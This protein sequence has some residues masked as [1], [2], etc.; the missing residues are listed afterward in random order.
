[1]VQL[2]IIN[3]V[4]GERKNNAVVLSGGK[5]MSRKGREENI[6]K[7][8]LSFAAFAV[9]RE[10]MPLSKARRLDARRESLH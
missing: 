9:L 7:S 3:R 5:K 6:R 2:C 4:V 8:I 1:L 10:I